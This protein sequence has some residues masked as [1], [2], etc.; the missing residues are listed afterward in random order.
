M[1]VRFSFL[2]VYKRIF[3]DAQLPQMWRSAFY[4]RELFFCGD[5]TT[6][7]VDLISIA[8]TPRRGLGASCAQEVMRFEEERVETRAGREDASKEIDARHK[9]MAGRL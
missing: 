3:R 7:R 9:A 4:D 8:V 1:S 2:K 6:S 5:A